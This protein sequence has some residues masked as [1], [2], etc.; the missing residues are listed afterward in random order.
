MAEADPGCGFNGRGLRET[1]RLTRPAR[2]TVEGKVA[3]W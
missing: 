1:A 2:L 3:V